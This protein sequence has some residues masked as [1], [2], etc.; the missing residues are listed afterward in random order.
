MPIFTVPWNTAA[1]SNGAHTIYA[2]IKDFAGNTVTTSTITI[3]ASNAV[4]SEEPV[5]TPPAPNADSPGSDPNPSMPTTT[6]SQ[7]IPLGVLTFNS[8]GEFST[9]VVEAVFPSAVDPD[10]NDGSF[11]EDW[12]NVV[13]DFGVLG[14]GTDETTKIQAALDAASNGPKTKVLIPAGLTV[15]VSPKFIDNCASGYWGRMWVA[16]F[17]DSNVVLR[18]DGILKMSKPTQEQLNIGGASIISNRNSFRMLLGSGDVQG[19]TSKYDLVVPSG[20]TGDTQGFVSSGAHNNSTSGVNVSFTNNPDLSG[21]SPGTYNSFPD[22][23]YTDGPIRLGVVGGF[24]VRQLSGLV[25]LDNT[26][27]TAVVTEAFPSIS[28]AS[29]KLWYIENNLIDENIIIEGNGTIDC[30]ARGESVD[31]DWCFAFRMARCRNLLIKNIRV[32]NY[33]EEA[34]EITL[35]EWVKIQNLTIE[36]TDL[37]LGVSSSEISLD[38]CSHVT[39]SDCNFIIPP[40]SVELFTSSGATIPGH[41]YLGTIGIFSW[42]T[43]HLIVKNCRYINHM[44]G[45]SFAGIVGLVQHQGYGKNALEGHGTIWGFLDEREDNRIIWNMAQSV[46]DGSTAADTFIEVDWN[47]LIDG[48]IILNNAAGMTLLG[49]TF[50]GEPGKGIKVVN[51]F[52]CNNDGYG[53]GLGTC[54]K[55]LIANNTIKNNGWVNGFFHFK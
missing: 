7:P 39:V 17:I 19:S 45:V 43:R 40:S 22:K 53:I 36:Q 4:P 20:F 12:I 3:T 1:S 5:T 26:A 28:S 25:S 14:D 42:A 41:D 30:D 9:L 38:C 32:I 16:L 11:T 35:S 55:I 34:L 13:R 21:A 24:G 33:Y 31:W 18:I 47:L 49:E 54:D 51:N 10:I 48:N 2:V 46:G 44:N 50:F 6:I 27:K 29:P 8:L 15:L 37:D 23:L 52:I